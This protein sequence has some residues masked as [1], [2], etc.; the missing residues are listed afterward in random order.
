[1]PV[2]WVRAEF[3]TSSVLLVSRVFPNFWTTYWSC[4]QFISHHFIAPS[5]WPGIWSRFSQTVPQL[6]S[7]GGGVV[8][9]SVWLQHK[10]NLFCPWQSFIFVA[11]APQCTFLGWR[12]GRTQ[13]NVLYLF[14]HMYLHWGKPNVDLLASWFNWK[15]GRSVFMSS[16]W[17]T[18]WVMQWMQ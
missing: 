16:Q 6:P 14:Q 3:W 5:F 12:T 4:E 11:P 8:I 17:R 15:L 2:F 9:S 13:G 1:M 18:W 7:E 10:W